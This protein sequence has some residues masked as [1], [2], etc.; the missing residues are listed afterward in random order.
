M[1]HFFVSTAFSYGVNLTLDQAIKRAL[2]NNYDMQSSR[3]GFE[4]SILSFQ[5]SWESF[6]LPSITLDA[7]STMVKTVGSLSDSDAQLAD[8]KSFGYPTSSISLSI[9]YS[10]YNFGRDWNSFHSESLSFTREKQSIV[11]SERSMRFSVVQSYFNLRAAQQ[12]TEAALRSVEVSKAIV[13]LM[14]S[15]FNLG[16]VSKTE[17]SSSKVD[18]LD[19]KNEYNEKEREVRSYLW[20]IN[21]LLGDP[22]DT[23]YN[24]T[25]EIRYSQL[26]ITKDEAFRIFEKNSPT[27]K[28]AALSLRQSE[29][30]LDSSEK[31]R[32]PLPSIEI[33]GATAATSHGYYGGTSTL[34]TDDSGNFNVSASVSVSWPILGSGGLFSNRSMQQARISRDQTEIS[35]HQSALEGKK[36]I[37]DYVTTIKQSEE[38]IKNLKES[39]NH[40]ASVLGELFEQMSAGTI[41]R[42]ELRDAIKEARES[43]FELNDAILDHLGNKL[44]LAEYIGL[45]N[46]PGDTFK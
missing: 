22:I 46:L 33:S 23:Q 41:P 21:N 17:V 30:S 37:Y 1:S 39:F 8:E 26:L 38:N 14:Q 7:S 4:S 34:G 43:E 25:S 31:D 12:K 15:K 29:L 28:D 42:L 35:F 24:L 19:A 6:Y 32:L 18:Y 16:Q 36:T 44:S 13:D 11:E 9:S 20:E 3:M 40:S 27:M 5:D 45:D 2:S 10:L